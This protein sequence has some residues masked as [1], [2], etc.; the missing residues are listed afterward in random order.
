MD[1]A[2]EY[3]VQELGPKPGGGAISADSV[4]LLELEIAGV[5]DDNGAEDGGS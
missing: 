4:K 1:G 2:R 5:D 3:V